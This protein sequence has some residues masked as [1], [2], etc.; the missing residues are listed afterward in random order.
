MGRGE[1]ERGGGTEWEWV[2]THEAAVEGE[3]G[4]GRCGSLRKV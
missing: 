4:G 2:L 1:G 3:G